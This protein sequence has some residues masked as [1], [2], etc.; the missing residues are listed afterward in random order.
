MPA[1]RLS[2]WCDRIVEAGWLI[3]MI[4]TPLFINMYSRRGFEAD[5][6]ALLRGLA[7]LMTAA[8]LIGWLDRQHNQSDT[9][10]PAARHFVK[11]ATLAFAAL[12]LLSSAVSVAPRIA[13]LGSYTRA[14]GAYTLLSFAAIALIVLD[15][16]QTRDQWQRLIN[17]IVLGSVPVAI[18][19]LLQQAD[20]DPLW[21]QRGAGGRAASTLGNPIY[22]AAYV[23]L[24]FFVTVGLITDS[25]SALRQNVRF[26]LARTIVYSL[27]ALLQIAALFAADSRGPFLGWLAG[28]IV[29]ALLIAALLRRRRL[30]LTA[31]VI[32][33]LGGVLLV[34]ANLPNS[35]LTGLRDTLGLNRLLS[36]TANPGDSADVRTLIWQGSADLVSASTPL[37]LAG[38][39]TD[40]LHGVR[41]IVGYGPDTMYLVFQQYFPSELTTRG[42]YPGDTL[43]GRSHNETWDV[44]ITGGLAGLAAYQGLMLAAWLSGLPLLGL[45][46]SKRD[47][48]MFIGLWLSGGTLGASSALIAN[49]PHYLGVSLPLGTLFG[50]IIYVLITALRSTS[51][52]TTTAVPRSD[53]FFATTLLAAITAHYV[54]TQFGIAVSATRLLFWLALALLGVLSVRRLAQS[55]PATNERWIGRVAAHTLLTVVMLVTLLF[56]FVVNYEHLS[57]PL[58]VIARA[59]TYDQP[60]GTNSLAAVALLGLS[61]LTAM[62]LLNLEWPRA[63]RRARL[64]AT[65]FFALLSLS[66]I[67]AWTVLF[68]RQPGIDMVTVVGTLSEELN[69]A[70]QQADL[71][72]LFMVTLLGLGLLC[73]LALLSVQIDRARWIN[74]VWSVAAAVLVIVGVIV[75]NRALNLDPIRAD[76]IY[77]QGLGFEQQTNTEYAAGIYQA[78]LALSPAEDVYY[79]GLGAV[80]LKAAQFEDA[81]AAF[82]QAR[83]LMPINADYA[84]GLA[85]AYNTWSTQTSDRTL[86]AQRMSLANQFYAEAL[87]LRP[88]DAT[89][90]AAASGPVTP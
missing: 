15:R 7:T 70:A 48:W 45:M 44:L 9:E 62:T 37:Q 51:A 66:L 38:S 8:W 67:A 46:S 82:A 5:K 64:R 89:L 32:S 43:V 23:M 55:E 81:L 71:F 57:N 60:H 86:A 11:W 61:W 27:I 85:Q 28:L 6:L 73:S 16:L 41:S 20:L 22:L 56:A 88:N 50:L 63:D 40:P 77:R 74:R 52:A 2:Q 12:T 90:Q 18:Y 4:V 25:L 1:S 54:E 35:P 58:E 75:L 34:V 87:R 24:T 10:Q 53:Q 14:Q 33:A 31:L 78:A 47:R 36:L 13:W 49:A 39:A 72:T 26:H 76:M 19:A 21:G 17:A 65:G 29:L 42:G 79:R 69:I 59:L 68:A 3:A 84:A 80:Y 30:I 83:Q